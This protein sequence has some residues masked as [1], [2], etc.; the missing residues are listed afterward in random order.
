MVGR[1]DFF[2]GAAAGAAGLVVGGSAAPTETEAADVPRPGVLPP[3]EADLQAEFGLRRAESSGLALQ[4]EGAA[5]VTTESEPAFDYMVEVANAEQVRAAN[6]DSTRLCSVQTRGVIVTAR[7]RSTNRDETREVRNRLDKAG[8][9][10][11]GTVA[12]GAKHRQG[13]FYRKRGYGS[14]A[15]RY[16]YG[17]QAEQ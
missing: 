8:I 4:Q 13:Y 2:K 1:R 17:Y 10:V 5:Q 14:Y 16:G 15:H 12:Q 7:L 9:R 3:T 6:P 11:I